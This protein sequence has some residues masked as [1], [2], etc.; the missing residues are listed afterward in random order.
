MKQLIGKNTELKIGDIVEYNFDWALN[1][2]YG[3]ALQVAAV[4]D[5][6]LQLHT[7]IDII[8]SSYGDTG[9]TI[10]CKIRPEIKQNTEVQE[11]SLSGAVVAVA[12]SVAVLGSWLFFTFT[13]KDIYKIVDSP[14]VKVA[15]YT[16]LIVAGIVLLYFLNKYKLLKGS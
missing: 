12:V 14:A 15:S 8:K 13:A 2:T 1:W 3:K 6:L 16:G 7:G 11:A 5:R 4:E 9:F 10:T